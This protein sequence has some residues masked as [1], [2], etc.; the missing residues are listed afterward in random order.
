[1]TNYCSFHFNFNSMF[2]WSTC[3]TDRT[4]LLQFTINV[5]K[6]E[7]HPQRTFEKIAYCSSGFIVTFLNAGSSI[8]NA[9]NSVSCIRLS[10][11][12]FSLNP[13]PQTEVYVY[14]KSLCIYSESSYIYSESLCI[15]S[16]SPYM[17]I[18]MKSLCIYS[19]SPHIYSKSLCIYSKS[20]YIYIYIRNHSAYTPNYPIYKS[21]H[22]KSLRIYSESPHMY[23]K[24][25]CIYSE[26]SYIYTHSESLCIY[27]ES[28]YI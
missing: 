18:H 5:R 19:E 7:C 12:N 11:A 14:S 16:E 25:L 21:I 17:S 1:M 10:F 15:Y 9:S 22:M 13:T 28:P 3:Y 23:L 6:S 26:S 4:T 27:S 8:Q 20:S 24:S 2:K